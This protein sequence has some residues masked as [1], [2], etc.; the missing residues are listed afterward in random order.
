MPAYHNYVTMHDMHRKVV[1]KNWPGDF[2]LQMVAQ[3]DQMRNSGRHHAL[4]VKAQLS[5]LLGELQWEMDDRPYYSV[6][7]NLVTKLCQV[8]F[9]KVPSN[10]ITMPD[11]FKVVSIRLNQ[12]N[13]LLSI[14]NGKYF[15][16]SMLVWRR[17]PGEILKYKG[18]TFEMSDDILVCW[19]DFGETTDYPTKDSP[20]Y[21]YKCFPIKDGQ[22]ITDVF[23]TFEDAPDAQ[24]GVKVPKEF[25]ENC[26][27]LFI[28]IGFLAASDTP[29][30]MFDI[31]NKDLGK[32]LDADEGKRKLMI[33]RAKRKG[34][35][36]FLIGSDQILNS[37][38]LQY[39]HIRAGHPHLYW[40]GKGK[41][42]IKMRFVAPTTV[43]KDRPFKPDSPQMPD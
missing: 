17:K 21:T 25:T 32:W 6:H 40:Y 15:L 19:I 12:E 2:Y 24:L 5:Q 4:D 27:K 28:S 7:P 9:S 31:L 10:L 29:L 22:M 16:K 1:G 23:D 3:L 11:P 26:V 38:E 33:A 37:R 20:L 42:K 35:N 8:D 13:E 39:S 41:K 30:M 43:R 36:G 18:Q 14:E 34:K